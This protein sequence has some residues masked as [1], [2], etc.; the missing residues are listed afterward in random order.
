MSL[1]TVLLLGVL[2]FFLPRG[3]LSK[4][5]GGFLAVVFFRQIVKVFL[6]GLMLVFIAAAM[7]LGPERTLR[8][9][10]EMGHEIAVTF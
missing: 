7:T 4:A 6:C 10:M 2:W 1:G 5:I 3:F 8:L 9:F